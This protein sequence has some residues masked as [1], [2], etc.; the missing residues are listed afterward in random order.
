MTSPLKA[1]SNIISSGVSALE[2][3]YLAHGI[4]FPSL[5][6]PLPRTDTIQLERDPKLQETTKLLVAAAFQLIA[7]VNDPLDTLTSMYA[8]GMYTSAA[9]QVVVEGSVADALEEE[10]PE[11]GAHV[12]QIASKVR[13]EDSSK[14]AR[15]LRYLADRHCFRE[16]VPNVFANNR[17]S[18]ALAK[19]KPLAEIQANP[20]K[21]YDGAPIASLIGH[22]AT[23]SLKSAPYIASSIINES[24]QQP[25]RLPFNVA[26]GT[27]QTLWEW[28]EQ[29]DNHFFGSRFA[30]GFEGLSTRFSDETFTC[31]LDWESMEKGSVVVD[32]GGSVGTVTAALA[33]KFSHLSYVVQDL[34]ATIQNKTLPYWS[35]RDPEKIANGQVKLQAH[36]FFEPQPIQHAS[37]YFM[38]FITHDWPTDKCITILKHL[39]DAAKPDTK[40]V[41]FDM[42]VLYSCE[43][44]GPFAFAS[45]LPNV[46][47]PLL[48]NLGV[49][50]GGFVT[51]TDMHMLCL[52]GS[53]ERTV[54]EFRLLGEKSG[55]KLDAVKPDIVSTLVYTTM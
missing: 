42:I 31:A 38:R 8:P 34:P 12:D 13:F 17:I 23:E 2:S 41:L 32:V 40:L 51:V 28:Y 30:T 55:W 50:A 29:P 9:L 46:P 14:L 54:D 15:I 10:D 52:L 6:D 43:D 20:S 24:R 25:S 35:S 22:F 47:H 11:K 44:P 26:F 16:V 7:T 19:A 49:G 5:D 48:K 37:V 4:S 1:L 33:K 36:S 3:A 21:Q 27:D 45:N 39:R 18:A 53:Q